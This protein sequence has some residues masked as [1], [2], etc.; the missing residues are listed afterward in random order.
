MSPKVSKNRGAR[1]KTHRRPERPCLCQ[2]LTL[3]PWRE[4]VVL[5]YLFVRLWQVNTTTE[6]LA[7]NRLPGESHMSEVTTERPTNKLARYI[8]SVRKVAV[9]YNIAVLFLPMGCTVSSS[10]CTGLYLSGRQMCVW[11]LRSGAMWHTEHALKIYPQFRPFSEF[12]LKP[13]LC[14]LKKFKMQ[15]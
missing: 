4:V 10:L 7:P 13:S 6:Q 14:N 8:T 9:L 12:T 1:P 11:L 3:E 15:P 2:G 5:S